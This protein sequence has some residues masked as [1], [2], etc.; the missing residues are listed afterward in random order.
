[1]GQTDTGLLLLQDNALIPWLILVPDTDATEL[2]HLD[3]SLQTRILQDINHVC[4][5]LEKHMA[6]DK[7]NIAT[8][9]NIVQQ[10][11]VHI[12][13]RR[14]DDKC[15]P[16]VVWGIEKKACYQADEVSRFKEIFLEILR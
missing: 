2:Y 14:R 7:I 8:I 12:V 1:M 9:G 16:G 4:R 10:L 11:H 15:W 6:F 5:V 13:A 3:F